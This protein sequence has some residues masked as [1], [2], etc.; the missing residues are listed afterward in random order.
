MGCSEIIFQNTPFHESS[1]ENAPTQLM[2]LTIFE[3]LK[4]MGWKIS[5]ALQL[6][7]ATFD[8]VWPK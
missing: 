6:S 8:K 1:S 3:E 2:F 7:L 4:K 5:G